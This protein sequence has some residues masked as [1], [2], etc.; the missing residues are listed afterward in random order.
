MVYTDPFAGN[1]GCTTGV[2]CIRC[3]FHVDWLLISRIDVYGIINEWLKYPRL[4][5]G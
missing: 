3:Y 2:L 5:V 1:E 4:Q